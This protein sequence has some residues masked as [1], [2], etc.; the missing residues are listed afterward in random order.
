MIQGFNNK[1]IFKKRRNPY[2]LSVRGV[3]LGALTQKTYS[4]LDDEI[5]QKN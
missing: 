2:W 3:N 5:S 1:N 4:L